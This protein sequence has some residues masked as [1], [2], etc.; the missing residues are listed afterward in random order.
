MT[1]EELAKKLNVDRKTLT[2]WQKNRPELLRLVQIGV[3]NDINYI[4]FF[5]LFMNDDLLTMHDFYIDFWIELIKFWIENKIENI[6]SALIIFLMDKNEIKKFNKNL[7]RID[8]NNFKRESFTKPL[9]N[10]SQNMQEYIRKN[11]KNKFEILVDDCMFNKDFKKLKSAINISLLYVSKNR[12]EYNLNY[13]KI[14]EDDIQKMY[15]NYKKIIVD[16]GN[17]N[18]LKIAIK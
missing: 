8:I 4:K 16:L 15:K 9:F 18:I 10:V 17:D 7:S 14:K 3:E 11:A 13:Q 5:E 2:N 6:E 1:K 12:Q